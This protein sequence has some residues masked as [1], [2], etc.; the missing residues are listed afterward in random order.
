MTRYLV[1]ALEP[2]ARWLF[3]ATGRHRPVPPPVASGHLDASPR[4]YRPPTFTEEQPSALVRPYFLAHEACT[5]HN[6]TPRRA[7][8]IW[9]R[10]VAAYPGGGQA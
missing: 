8:L 9:A 6:D 2:T 1:R 5:R 4:L 3:P 7:L 10:S